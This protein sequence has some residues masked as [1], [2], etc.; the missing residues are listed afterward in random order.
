MDDEEEAFMQLVLSNAQGELTPLEI[1][2]HALEA[3]EKGKGGR[4]ISGELSA[5]S[6]RIGKP[7]PNVVVYRNAAEGAGTGAKE[8]EKPRAVHPPSGKSHAPI[9]GE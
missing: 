3:V 1:G 4:G 5:Y 6:E 2:I 8:T 9:L 7:R